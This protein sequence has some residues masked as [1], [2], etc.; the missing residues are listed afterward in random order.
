MLPISRLLCTRILAKRC[1]YSTDAKKL[2][3]ETKAGRMSFSLPFKY[4]SAEVGHC[5][6]KGGVNK[7]PLARHAAKV[8]V[9]DDL[10]ELATGRNHKS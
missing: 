8:C 4:I 1:A 2:G 6:L 3:L 9:I 10:N 5:C 7:Y